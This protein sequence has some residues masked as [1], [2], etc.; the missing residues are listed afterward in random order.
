M[1]GDNS[2]EPTPTDTTIILELTDMEPN[3]RQTVLNQE[4]MANGRSHSSVLTNGRTISFNTQTDWGRRETEF[5]C[6][7]CREQVVRTVGEFLGII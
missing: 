3:G 2:R 7:N 6:V 4:P 1:S 5:N